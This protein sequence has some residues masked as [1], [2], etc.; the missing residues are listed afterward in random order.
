[1]DM[2]DITVLVAYGSFGGFVV[3]VM[4]LLW[5]RS[6]QNPK[7]DSMTAEEFANYKYE[8]SSATNL[9]SQ[10][11]IEAIALRQWKK[12]MT[13]AA[14]HSDQVSRVEDVKGQTI[15]HHAALFR[16][17][18]DVMEF[19]LWAAPELASVPNKDGELA[20]HWAVRLSTPSPILSLLLEAYPESAFFADAHGATPISL[21]W[22]RHQISLLTIWRTERQRLLDESE[23]V[24]KRIMYVYRT[25]HERAIKKERRELLSRS[26]LFHPLHMAAAHA[27]PPC[28][29]P[30]M[31]QVYKED[32]KVRDIHGRL[33]L[34]IACENPLANRSCDVLTKI[35]LLLREYPASA[36]IPDPK[37][38]QYPLFLALSSGVLWNDGVYSLIHAFPVALSFRDPKLGLYAFA[39]AALSKPR[40]VQ[41]ESTGSRGMCLELDTVYNTLRADPSVLRLCGF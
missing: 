28:L 30:L 29:Y 26:N 38:G 34:S 40:I 41:H 6:F 4:V 35:Q 23:H 17:P 15:L 9:L 39:V 7:E 33:A 8:S 25:L 27:S 20:L 14:F 24:W 36:R 12:V 3:L 13:W 1:M 31:I 18:A 5:R 11:H 16:A 2:M 32:L 22:E 37:S 19:L 10:E 21:L